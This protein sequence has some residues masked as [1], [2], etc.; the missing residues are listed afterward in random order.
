M[1]E[2]TLSYMPYKKITE[3]DS[4]YKDLEEKSIPQILEE[5]SAENQIPARATEQALPRIT[6]LVE[7]MLPRLKQGGR[8]FYVG[9]G[10]SGR[11]G[12]LDASEI[13]PTFGASED[14]F[15]GLIAGGDRA[16]RHSVE[17]AEDSTRQALQDL[18]PYHLQEADTLIGITAAGSAPYVLSA[19]VEAR[20]LGLLTACITSNPGSPVTDA[21]EI[22][23]VT[24]VGPEYVTGSSRLKSGTAQKMVLNMISTSLMIKMGRVKGNKMVDMQLTNRKLLE[25]GVRIIV[26]ETGVT[27][28]KAE[29]ILLQTRSVR[30]AIALLQEKTA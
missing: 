8:V 10:T 15:I 3:Q 11:L 20:R 24:V 1:T 21:A 6:Q 22:A 27:P 18:A 9:A 17:H 19:I 26:E 2:P 5:M 14:L 28:Q 13:P 30:K 12:V 29:Q 16:L 25:R 23:I 7:A 4:A